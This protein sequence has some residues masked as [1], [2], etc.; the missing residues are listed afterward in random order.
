MSTTLII[1]LAVLGGFLLLIVVNQK[2]MKNMPN[3]ENS[4]K[5]KVL[6]VKNFKTQT[7]SGLVLV[8]FW[9]PWC[10]PCKMM[11]P[12][13]NDVAEEMDD[14]VLIGK[15]NI[16]QNQIIAKKNKVKSI[17]TLVLYQDGQEINR[18]VGVKNKKFLVKELRKYSKA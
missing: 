17:P 2:R 9:A 11:A 6:N 4:K 18:F 8:D 14:E 13:L 10:G 3:I 7:K 16:D 12:V 1:V 5:I 15:L